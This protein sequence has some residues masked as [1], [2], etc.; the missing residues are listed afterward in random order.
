ME[1]TKN[2]QFCCSNM[3]EFILLN[4]IIVMRVVSILFFCSVS[5]KFK[6][7][8]SYTR[9]IVIKMGNSRRPKFSKYFIQFSMLFITLYQHNVKAHQILCSCSKASKT[10]STCVNMT[11]SIFNEYIFLIKRVHY[12]I[13]MRKSIYLKV[14]LKVELYL[15]C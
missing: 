5:Y 4:N 6:Y 13:D 11:L 7:T 10:I 1:Y 3:F 2:V 14:E 8:S 12:H 15:Q 9:S